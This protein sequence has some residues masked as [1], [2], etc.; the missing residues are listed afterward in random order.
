MN[1]IEQQLQVLSTEELELLAW[2]INWIET[3]RKKQITPPGDWWTTWLILAGRGFGKTRT[4]AEDIGWY[5]SEHANVFCGVIAPTSADI[6]GTCF[7]GESGLLSVIPKSMVESYNRSFAEI[8]LIN[9]STIRGFSAEEP[10]RLR[11]PQFHRAWCDE[12]AAWKYAQE[13]WDM[14]KFGLRLGQNPQVVITTTP[15]PIDLVRELVKLANDEDS[16]VIMT[17]GSTYENADHLAKSFIDEMASYEGTQLGRQELYAELI[18]PEEGGIVRRSWF[19]LWPSDRPFPQ[20]EFIVQ[21]YDTAFTE[22]TEGDPT[23]CTVWGVFKP[24]DKPMSVMILDCWSEHLSYPDLKPRVLDDY[25]ASYGEPGKRVDLVLI[26]EKGS[27]ISLIQDLQRANV[28]VR[29]YNPGRADKVQRLHIVS[30]IISAGRVYVPESDTRPG[31]FRS[32][33]NDFIEQICS[34]PL[35]TH[36]D[37]VDTAS[38]VLRVLRDMNFLN[39]DPPPEDLDIYSDDTRPRRVNPYAQ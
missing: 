18:D 6:R 34:F 36:D 32:W 2:R 25:T 9:G 23:A 5:A 26:E 10:S 28:Y 19:K 27:G 20:F 14:L 17:T 16:A 29:A 8:T 12:L 3:A 33:A 31:Q 7:E 39:I 30:N 35:A 38:Q 11:G 13:T 22:K 1:A 37:Y 15:K 4:G 21:S 24:M